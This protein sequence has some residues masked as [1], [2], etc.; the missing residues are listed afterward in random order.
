MSRKIKVAIVGTN[1]IPARYGGFETLTE[2]LTGK[3]LSDEFDFT[4]YCSKTSREQRLKEFNGAK[5]VNICLSELTALKVYYM[6]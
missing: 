5:L 4:V 2:Y 1:G 3:Y 6:I